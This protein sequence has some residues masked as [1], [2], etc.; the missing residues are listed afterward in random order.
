L[1]TRQFVRVAFGKL[2][3]EGDKAEQFLDPP[4]AGALPAGETVGSQD[5]CKRGAD[6]QAGVERRE[7]VLEH[8]LDPFR[9]FETPDALQRLAQEL[10]AAGRG[11]LQP[12]EQASKSRLPAAA[13][14][15]HSEGGTFWQSE[16]NAP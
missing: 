14:A 3:G 16:G 12:D 6:A 2:G 8:E 4:P 15:D 11:L 1:A 9:P 13:F 10:Y 5:F 7:G